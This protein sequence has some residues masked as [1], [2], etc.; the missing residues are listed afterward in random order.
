VANARLLGLPVDYVQTYRQ[1]LSGVTA[2]QVQSAARSGIRAD[3]ALIVV[4]GDAT[5]VGPKLTPIAPVT[6]V[7]V[8]GNAIAQGELNRPVTG[9]T[10]DVARMRAAAD[11]FSILFQGQALGAQVNTLERTQAGW[12]AT[13][14]TVLGPV[15]EQNSEVHL[16]PGGEMQ[17]VNLSGRL[18]GQDVRLNVRFQDG[19]ATGSGVSPSAEG[20]KPVEFRDVEVP[21]GVLD[22]NAV[23]HMLPFFSWAP[24]AKFDFSVFASGKGVIEQRTLTVTGQ[25][26][27][28]VPLGTFQAYRV[29][30]SG[31][32]A[33]GTYW[34][35][36]AAPHRVLKF[37]PSAIPLEFVRVR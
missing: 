15:G 7:D 11:S 6:M 18:Q 33:P 20:P 1:R 4:V 29:S 30:Y 36:A 31:G 17:S 22:D 28:T 34:I 32:E 3:A 12:R 25:E 37:G 2:A 21:A 9:V 24:G 19:K 14:R 23:Q 27:V 35:E 13:E 26:A 5:V 8:D 10:L 16:G